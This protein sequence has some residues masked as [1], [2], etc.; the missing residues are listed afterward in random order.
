MAGNVFCVFLCLLFTADY[1]SGHGRFVC[2]RPPTPTPEQ[3]TPLLEDSDTVGDD[4]YLPI[5]AHNWPP[6]ICV[7]VYTDCRLVV[8]HIVTLLQCIYYYYDGMSY[9]L[10]HL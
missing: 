6:C 7:L 4:I 3:V 1:V 2:P 5:R 8:V 9:R 10:W